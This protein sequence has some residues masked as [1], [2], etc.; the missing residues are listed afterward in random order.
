VGF[1]PP[2]KEK[3]NHMKKLQLYSVLALWAMLGMGMGF[4]NL[5]E[6]ASPDEKILSCQRRQACGKSPAHRLAAPP[7]P[8]L[9]Q[10]PGTSAGSAQRT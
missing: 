10:P 4:P 8:G 6:E 2:A 7:L 5:V 9:C 1:P 3:P